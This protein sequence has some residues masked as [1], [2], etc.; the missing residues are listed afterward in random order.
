MIAAGQALVLTLAS[1]MHERPDT[2]QEFVGLKVARIVQRLVNL[3]AVE[4]AFGA[5]L[6]ASD[7]GRIPR[8][9]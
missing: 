4:E 3:V 2:E 1:R 6:A 8:D 5:M 7:L 9:R